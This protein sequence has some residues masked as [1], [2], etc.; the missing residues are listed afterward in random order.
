MRRL[1][2]LTTLALLGTALLAR[3]AAAQATITV[4]D[5][6]NIRFGVLGQFW[7][8]TLT[9]PTSDSHSNN[10]FVRRLRLIT[11]GNVSQHVGFFVETDAPNLGRTVNGKNIT[12]GL[13]L[14]DAFATFTT[15]NAFMVDAGLMYVPF[16][17]NSVQSAA[18]LLPVDFGAYTFTQ[19]AATQSSTGRDT[20]FQAR[21][22]LAGNHLEYRLAAFQGIRD[23]ASHNGFRYA[24]RLQLDLLD[25]EVGFFYTGTYL[26]KKRV[27]ALGAAFDTQEQ[28]HAY[29]ADA[30]VD[31]PLWVGA[32]TGQFDYNRFNGQTFLPTIPQQNAYLAEGGFLVSAIKVTPF[33]QWTNR[34]LTNSAATDEHRTSLGAAYWWAAHNATV[35]AAW[36]RISPNVAGRQ[37][38]FTLQLQ[39]FYF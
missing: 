1:S 37:D 10:L 39:I 23:A 22:Y 8:D 21:G 9:D 38:E 17:R 26:G 34:D 30:F 15:T 13:I 25:P 33:V 4:N 11:G 7:A 19:S 27:L 14:Q 20:G 5:A 32:V 31:L 36:T 29:D 2:T 35:K 6:V 16:S 12:P 24:G 3:P 28:Y 18:T